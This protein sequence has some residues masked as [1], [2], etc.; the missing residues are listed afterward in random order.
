MVPRLA[1]GEVRL[2]ALRGNQGVVPQ[3][4]LRRDAAVDRRSSRISGPARGAGAGAREWDGGLE[5]MTDAE[6]NMEYAQKYI[7]ELYAVNVAQAETIDGLLVVKK[8][9]ADA[10]EMALGL[11]DG[12]M[13]AI[14]QIRAALCLAGRLSP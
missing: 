14:T 1:D 3:D 13:D 7:S 2:P 12:R 5:A 8:H 10:L 9:L 4:R 6:R 11:M